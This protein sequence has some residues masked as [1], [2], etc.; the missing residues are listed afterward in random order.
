MGY[1]ESMSDPA[2]ND[3]T[4]GEANP[5]CPFAGSSWSLAPIVGV[6]HTSAPE[7]VAYSAWGFGIEVVP[8]YKRRE[9][10][11]NAAR[12]FP[13]A[14]L[15]MSVANM[16]GWF[17]LAPHGC[18]AK[19]NGGASP[20]DIVVSIPDPPPAPEARGSGTWSKAPP[21]VHAQSAVGHGILTWTLGYVFR[22]PPGW[23]T[24]CRG[25][26]NFIKDGIAPLEG[27]VETDWTNSSFSMNWKFTRPGTVTFEK[28][29]PIAMLVPQRRGELE[30]FRCRKAEFAADPALADGYRKWIE[31]RVGFLDKQRSG[32]QAALKQRFE[33]HYMHGTSV[34]GR[35]G[36]ED[37]QMMRELSRFE[38]PRD[39]ASPGQ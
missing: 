24:L 19:W 35:P 6:P 32:D 39:A 27:L 18:I 14:C 15:P 4:S 3:A 21:G 36:P 20:A 13:Y 1:H 26:A 2:P 30:T 8:A 33:K 12:G 22:T 38:E 31:S 10:M 9:W 29:E 23:N 17:V 34:D 7:I 11:D 16:S 28:G 25:P 37:H 5:G